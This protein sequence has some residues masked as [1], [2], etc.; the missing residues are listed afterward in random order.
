M[1]T[2][3]IDT[4]KSMTPAERAV[5]VLELTEQLAPMIKEISEHE[6]WIKDNVPPGKYP[7][8]GFK[9]TRWNQNGALD[10]IKLVKDYSLEDH[11][12]MY[13][14]VA[15]VPQMRELLPREEYPDCYEDAVDPAAAK[16]LLDDELKPV[17]FKQV[18]YLKI[19]R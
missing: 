18:P 7:G 5:R 14:E 2:K 4:E 12:E 13:R 15:L 1:T 10:Q 9:V 17:Y 16:E 3:K 11:P 6:A 8:E 19:T